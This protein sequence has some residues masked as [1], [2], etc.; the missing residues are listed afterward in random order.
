MEQRNIFSSHLYE[1]V[2]HLHGE[3]IFF[4][5][6]TLCD[7]RSPLFLRNLFLSQSVYNRLYVYE[8]GTD[9]REGKIRLCLIIPLLMF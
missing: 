4:W 7:L 2:N 3:I 6:I 9:R 1:I 8:H 5:D